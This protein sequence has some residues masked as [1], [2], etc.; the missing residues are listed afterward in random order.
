MDSNVCL[1]LTKV[2][3]PSVHYST[4]DG[5]IR[6]SVKFKR[7]LF[8]MYPTT[9]DQR[10]FFNV[11]VFTGLTPPMGG[12]KE[13]DDIMYPTFIP[14][15]KLKVRK[16]IDIQDPFREL[17][18]Y[19]DKRVDFFRKSLIENVTRHNCYFMSHEPCHG[20]YIIR[21]LQSGNITII[22]F[23]L[24]SGEICFTGLTSGLDLS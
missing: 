13:N 24:T 12:D 23:Q 20:L 15:P 1:S 22:N 11:L 16:T 3:A 19:G 14:G 5:L 21:E 7:D 2:L 18:R 6:W 17:N 9:P 10:E 4:T 8:R